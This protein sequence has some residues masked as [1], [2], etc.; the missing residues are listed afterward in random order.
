MIQN[1]SQQGVVAEPSRNWA[2]RIGLLATLGILISCAGGDRSIRDG[3]RAMVAMTIDDAKWSMDP[4]RGHRLLCHVAEWHGFEAMR[5]FTEE[6]DRT[7]FLEKDGVVALT[8]SSG[9][10]GIS[11]DDGSVR[12]VILSPHGHGLDSLAEGVEY[13]LRPRNGRSGHSWRVARGVSVRSPAA[14]RRAPRAATPEEEAE[15][16]ELARARLAAARAVESL[17]DRLAESGRVATLEESYAWSKRLLDS[18]LDLPE[19][20]RTKA[21]G[22]HLSRMEDTQE[23]IRM[24]WKAGKRSEMELLQAQY[25][26]A[27]ARSW[28]RKAQGE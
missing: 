9:I 13:A 22:D 25:H 19:V 24:L 6:A 3:A 16:A 17:S 5:A 4:V 26:V 28:F 21:F 20:R 1:P 27:E 10:G 14:G 7:F 18:E 8:L 12:S 11:N 15:T 23:E 2:R